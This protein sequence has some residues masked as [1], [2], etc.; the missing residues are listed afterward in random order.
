M[1]AVHALPL[2]LAVAFSAAAYAAPA[3]EDIESH[4][5]PPAPHCMD[6]RQTS[7]MYQSDDT[8]VVVA[9]TRKYYRLQLAGSCPGLDKDPALTMQSPG[10]WVCGGPEERFTT[11][12]TRCPV[13]SVEQIDSRQYAQHARQTVRQEQGKTLESVLVTATAG[14]DARRRHAR[15]FVGTADYCFNTAQIRGW[16]ESPEGMQVQVSPRRNA[17]NRSYMVQL[18]G[19]CPMLNSSP[20]IVFHSGSGMGVICGNAGDRVLGVRENFV[21]GTRAQAPFDS[22][23]PVMTGLVGAGTGSSYTGACTIAAVYPVSG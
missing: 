9:S 13:A 2:S 18:E 22:I 3:S 10:G 11:A 14:D 16:S 1:N 17:G 8:T 5:V 15:G 21:D 4:R 23:V 19:S 7:G 20:S 12:T 6:A